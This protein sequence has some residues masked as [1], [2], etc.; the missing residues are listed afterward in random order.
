[1]K[2]RTANMEMFLMI[3][4]IAETAWHHEGDFAFMKDLVLR[5][6]TESSADFVKLHI[7][8]N[9]DE[10]MAKDH[11]A[12][13]TLAGWILSAEQWKELI[14][15]V[16]S[17]DKK[18]MLLLNDT[19]A[20]EFATEFNPEIIELHSVCLNVPRLQKSV[21]SNFDKDTKIVI[22]VGGCTLQ[23][24]DA[25]VRVFDGWETVLMFG[26]QNYP[27]KY[28]DINLSKIRKV[29]SLYT[30]KQFGYADHTGWDENN[31]EY[32]TTLVAANGMDYV[33]KHVTT[34]YGQE[35]CDYSAAISM[36][37]FNKLSEKLKVLDQVNSDGSIALNSGE[38]A[39]SQ[40]GSMKMAAVTI[41][42]I[43]SGKELQ[44]SDFA[45]CRTGQVSDMGQIEI[46]EKVG[47]KVKRR[48]P[49]GQVIRGEDFL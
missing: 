48:I 26:F 32:I 33:E 4:L 19:K 39:Y 15:I 20:I 37:M 14:D 21:I 5:L 45:F 18:L 38:K 49:Q 43:L 28:E 22:G 24:V 47:E 46:M 25:A 12:Y 35:R 3:K 30:N 10:Y 41:Q 16:R 44:K 9:L 40:Y 34:A 8:L 23:E 29:Q 2:K 17:S 31:N 13:Q 36:D 7:T 6:C 27:T 11:P 1:M 42:D